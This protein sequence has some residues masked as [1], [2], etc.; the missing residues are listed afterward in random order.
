MLRGVV[1]LK[2]RRKRCLPGP[3]SPWFPKRRTGSFLLAE[4]CRTARRELGVVSYRRQILRGIDPA[5]AVGRAAP[6]RRHS[7]TDYSEVSQ[8]RTRR[9]GRLR[10]SRDLLGIFSNHGQMGD[11]V[12]RPNFAQ[13]QDCLQRQVFL[14][15]AWKSCGERSLTLGAYC[16]NAGDGNVVQGRHFLADGRF[17]A[18]LSETLRSGPPRVRIQGLLAGRMFSARASLQASQRMKSRGRICHPA[19]GSCQELAFASAAP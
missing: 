1:P 3:A 17:H 16:T 5:K 9:E 14:K 13:P 8:G 10:T 18:Q 11:N 19:T 4:D 12:R 2:M 15:P 7:Q 6:I